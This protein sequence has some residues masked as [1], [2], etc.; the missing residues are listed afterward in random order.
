MKYE[1]HITIDPI[2]PTAE[3]HKLIE[4][5]DKAK[6][7][8]AKLLKEVGFPSNLDQFMTGHGNEFN[9]LHGRMRLLCLLLKEAGFVI[10]RYKIEEILVDSRLGDSEGLL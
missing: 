4:L 10:R 6:F 8:V 5:C 7:K 1:C 9:E 3:M 2:I